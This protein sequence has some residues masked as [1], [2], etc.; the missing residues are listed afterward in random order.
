MTLSQIEN[1]TN[2]LKKKQRRLQILREKQATLGLS[3]PP[4]IVMEIE[5]ID[6]DIEDLQAELTRL[7]APL[8]YVHNFGNKVKVP[9]EAIDLDWGKYFAF[10]ES[11]RIVP[12]PETWQNEL[13]PVLKQLPQDMGQ[14]GLVRLR[15]TGA[16][17]VG[18][19]LGYTFREVAQY[20]LEVAQFPPNPPSFWY[21]DEL[22]PSGVPAP[23][24][25]VRQM[26]G[27][28]TATEAIVI[29]YATP[30]RSPQ[31]VC[32][33]IAQHW[34]IEDGLGGL[35]AESSQAGPEELKGVLLLEAKAAAKDERFIDGWEAAA[36]ARSSRRPLVDFVTLVKPERVH[37]FLAVPF[38][39]AVF[40]GHQWNAIGSTVQCYEWAGV[41]G[42]Y[43][44]SC[45]VGLT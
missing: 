3:V 31:S 4:E 39:L 7:N 5:D 22:P 34:G 37:L 45:S 8:I 38:G 44:P 1:L 30:N 9:P 36:L 13:L 26:L 2:V 18:F 19:A 35:F 29:V 43:L 11:R 32:Q 27:S 17:S 6:A 10:G 28:D 23:R 21:S 40:L 42:Q 15:T 16:L 33:A 41:S 20:K 14:R 12:N 24:F 25:K